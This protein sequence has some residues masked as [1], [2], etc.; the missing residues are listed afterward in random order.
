MA[1]STLCDDYFLFADHP[2]EI[3]KLCVFFAGRTGYLICAAAD[4]SSK[5]STSPTPKY[6][7]NAIR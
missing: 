5:R 7:G 3:G 2:G 4:L 1:W 6:F